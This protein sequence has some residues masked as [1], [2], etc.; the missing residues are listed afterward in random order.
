MGFLRELAP[1]LLSE[2]LGILVT[3]FIVDG[4]LER[5]ERLHWA[6]A[7]EI[8]ATQ[9]ARAYSA[10]MNCAYQL[11][12]PLLR[13][14]PGGSPLTPFESRLLFVRNLDK[15]I[16]RLQTVVDLNNAALNAQLM[17]SV[18]TF[19][20]V[21]EKLEARM[22]FLIGIYHPQQS[23][24]DFV[25]DNV[26]DLVR[27]LEI[28]VAPLKENYPG[29]WRDNKVV[30]AGLKAADETAALLAEA[31]HPRLRVF[32]D[33]ATYVHA[34]GRQLAVF[35]IST[36]RSIPT[37]GLPNGTPVRVHVNE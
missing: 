4:L 27:Q 17:S 35:D 36:L 37:N 5:R 7:R 9:V 2:G 12:V 33:A 1:N 15:Q 22:Q 29:P 25:C 21:A 3:Y 28:A 23:N 8:V 10:C 14:E 6:P 18:S 16:K 32:Y 24:V 30:F 34:Q 19:L 31:V 26:G 11:F 13:P 20:D